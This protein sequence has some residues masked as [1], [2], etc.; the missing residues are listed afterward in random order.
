MDIQHVFRPE[1]GVRTIG[2]QQFVWSCNLVADSDTAFGSRIAG[3]LRFEMEPHHVLPRLLIENHLRTL[4]DTAF[5]DRARLVVRDRQG[6]SLVF[7]VIQVFGRVAMDADQ[8]YISPFTFRFVLAEPIISVALLQHAA[9]MS[10]DVHAV[11]VRPDFT[12]F[13]YIP[14]L[15]GLVSPFTPAQSEEQQQRINNNSFHTCLFIRHRYGYIS[16]ARQSCL[17]AS[18]QIP[19]LQILYSRFP[20]SPS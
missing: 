9:A 2:G 17:P 10:I 18:E 12:G 15:C 14:G 5:Y 13:E 4:Q 11:V 20:Q 19:A 6:D 1:P 16:Q 3:A 7:P 8:G